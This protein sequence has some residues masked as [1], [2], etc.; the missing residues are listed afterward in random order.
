MRL[1]LNPAGSKFSLPNLSSVQLDSFNWFL[2]EGIDE[3]LEEISSIEDYTGRNWELT[4]SKSRISKPSSTIE[5]AIEKGITYSAS[6]F[7]TATLKDKSTNQEKSQEIYVGEIPMITSKGTFIINGIEK[8]VVSQL[9]RSY[10][11]FFVSS[12]DSSTGRVLGGAKILPKNG[13]WLEFETAKSGVITV[14]I[15]RKRKIAATTLLR[16]FGLTD[17][18]QLRKIFG[19][20]IDTTL[21]KDSAKSYNE[22]LI[23]IYKKMRPGEPLVLENAKALVENIFFNPRRYSLG[24]VGRFKLNQR[25]GFDTPNNKDNWLLTKDDLVAVITKVIALN[26]GT[27]EPDDID[28]LANRRVRSVGEL[29]QM[30]VRVGFIQMERNIKERMSLQ[31]RGLLCEPQSLISTRPV[32]ARVHSFFALGQL[33]QYQDQSNPLTGLDHLRRL[34]VLGPGGLSKERASF[35]VRDV[36]FSHY[37]RICPVRTPE[38]PNIGLISYLS[39]FARVN[40]YGFLETPYRK[41]VKEKNGK[42]RVTEEIVYMAAYDEDKGFIADASPEIDKKGF[43]VEKLVPLRKGEEFIIGNIEM[44]DYMDINPQQ[45]VGVAAA[46]IPFLSNDDVNRALMGTQ[47]ATQAVPLVNPEEPLVGTGI[48]SA[49]ALNAGAVVVAEENGI[50]DYADAKEVVIKTSSGEKKKYLP[51]K[52]VQSNMDTCFNQKVVVSVGEKVKKGTVLM[53]GPSS[54][55]GVLSLGANLKVGYMIWEGFNYEDSIILSERVV[56]EDVLTSIHIT[57]HTVQILETKLGPEEITRD[58]PNVSEEVLRNLDEEGIVAIGSKVRSGDILVGK[59]APK[60]ESEL[61]AEERLLR[62]IFGEKAKDVKNNSLTLP[63]G[64]YGTV[65]GIKRIAASNETA[66]PNGVLEEITVF[67]AQQRKI[68]VGD[69]LA[70]RHGNKGVIAKIVPAEDMP[71]LEDGTPLDIILSPASV[72]ARM[73]VGQLLES[74]LGRVAELSG[75]KYDIQAFTKFTEEDLKNSLKKVGLPE[76][77]KVRLID[78]RTGEFFDQPVVVGTAYILKLHHLAEDKMH[79]RSIGPYSLITQQPLGGK[80]QFGGQRFGEMEVWALEAYSASHTLKEL[81]T[82][83]SDDVIGRTL[84]YRSILQGTEIPESA[85]PESFK[86][87]VRELNGLGLNIMPLGMEDEIPE[88]GETSGKDALD[89]ALEKAQEERKA[90]LKKD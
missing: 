72:I 42:V 58:I 78:G 79:A 55:N 89:E 8:V 30:Q 63:H 3:I 49:V 90:A 86:L 60:G 27:M 64:E 16:V 35:S 5:Q 36:H 74:H 70:G 73:N 11:V 41:L 24:K 21:N 40:E 38:G 18:D 50:I 14:K 29:L 46:L 23:E 17:D 31:P 62:A 75:E 48:E 53:E 88:T 54:S 67:I 71:C 57:D 69:K 26:K 25:F 20:F 33:S 83:K 19:D 68:M 51:L 85:V 32:Q 12:S 82:I 65:I 13:A 1:S 77:G 34:S 43:V 28:S 66:L 81:L 2:K 59:V 7:L 56:R 61:S 15:D 80:A 4:F 84:A 44:A 37:G 6:W 87:L 10:G 45:V 9:T 76:S 39:L 22:A 52:F 47:H